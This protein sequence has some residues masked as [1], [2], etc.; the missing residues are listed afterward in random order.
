MINDE[1]KDRILRS[2]SEDFGLSGEDGIT[3][4]DEFERA[5]KGDSDPLFY[6]VLYL[7]NDAHNATF[8]IHVFEF[9]FKEYIVLRDNTGDLQYRQQIDLLFVKFFKQTFGA[10]CHEYLRSDERDEAAINVLQ[11]MSDRMNN[12]L[13]TQQEMI[14]NLS[15]AMRTSLNGILGYLSA[16]KNESSF[17]QEAQLEYLKKTEDESA[18]LQALVSKILDISKI[19]AGQMELTKKPFWM[20][21]V[22]Y[23]SIE[24]FLA[25]MKR[26][27]LNFRTHCDFFPYQHVG[28]AQH[29]MLIITHLFQ[30]AVRYTDYG[31]IDFHIDIVERD[32]ESE[33]IAFTLH[34]TGRGMSKAQIKSVLDPY[35]RFSAMSDGA[36]TGLY[37]VSKLVRK[38]QG[39]LKIKSHEGQGT[40]V[41]FR[42][43]LPKHETQ[44]IDLSSE[45]FFFF[46]DKTLVN[47][48][49][50][51]R[52]NEFL[53]EHGAC[54]DSIEDEK[55]LMGRLLDTTLKAPTCFV[56]TTQEENYE[57][58]NGLIHYFKS[59][60]KF[61]NTKF[62]AQ[63]I[64][65]HALVNFFDKTFTYYVPLSAY[66]DLTNT[67]S[68]KLP[69]NDLK[70][71]ALRFLAVDDIATNLEVLKLFVKL[72]FPNAVLDM[73]S[74]G[75]EAVGMY[76][77][78]EY[79]IILLDLKMPGLSGYDVI[80]IFQKIKP[81]PPT[82]ALTADVYKKTFENISKVGFN[83]LLEKPIQ[84]KVLEETIKKALNDTLN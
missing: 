67:A 39:T 55:A 50:F 69:L 33:T 83:G 25:L 7:I 40:T 61:A 36:G 27:K 78:V 53:V 15:H 76:K 70:N 3:F 84:P 68:Q 66:I 6:R 21:D 56:L 52:L 77:T 62:F 5:I 74:G 24:E 46:N 37:I 41:S 49:K 20:E 59:L 29:I 30:N 32:A 28:D 71:R 17:L 9:V 57:R 31:S 18:Q 79:D 82:F 2:L 22:L 63:H 75:Y 73:A 14:I 1:A 64:S 58:Y 35:V 4:I 80:E 47:P 26:K 12:V 38:M 16:L 44:K 23:K 13:S 81:I 10:K 54:V 60:P 45:C 51:A 72:L 8:A 48:K 19:N 42:L 11:H 34:D 43:K 65:N